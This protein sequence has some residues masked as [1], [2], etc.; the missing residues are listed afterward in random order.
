MRQFIRTI[1]GAS[2]CLLLAGCGTN[3]ESILSV[4]GGKVQGIPTA[5]G[6]TCFRGIPY[7]AVPVG[8]LRWR[9]PQPVQPWKGVLMADTFS[10]ASVQ[11]AH[12]PSDAYYPEFFFKGDAP[13]SEDCLY[14]NVWTPAPGRE[15]AKLPVAVWIHGGGFTGGWGHE[16]EMDGNAWA[17]RGV[18][19]V[20]INYRLGVFGFLSHPLLSEEQGRQSGNYGLL[21]Q[22]A[23]L[24]WVRN[25]IAKF[26]GD[27]ANVTVFG[28]SAGARS[29][30]N[31]VM[32]DLTDGLFAKAIM[33]SGG[34]VELISSPT[35]NEMIESMTKKVFDWGGYDTLE[36][37]RAASTD[38]IFTLQ[39]RYSQSGE[40]RE[41]IS[42][43]VV[44]DNHV[45]HGTFS[46]A[47]VEGKVKDIPYMI[48]YTTNDMG[49]RSIGITRF[50]NIRKDAGK[51]VYLYEF[52][53]PLPDDEAGSHPL[54]GAFH[55]SE[56]WYVFKTLANSDRP[57]TEADYSLADKM[58]DAWTNFAKYSNPDPDGSIGWPLCDGADPQRMVFGLDEKCENEASCLGSVLKTD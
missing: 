31:L 58:V 12:R 25:N 48:G 38:D 55:S 35:D 57:F 34:G 1:I 27:P 39:A 11:S 4:D 3:S 53:R 28:Q 44:T 17:E 19:L 50:A 30:E 47:A 46:K 15:D 40:G 18:I 52:A 56:L 45:N 9:E 7:A 22:I 10:S 36:K 29:V 2:V 21:D 37:M 16:I 54:K 49:N 14:L 13:F 33:M 6:V 43:S 51:P 41:R 5:E 24:K 23:A 8:D 32:S 26:G 42:T 20:T